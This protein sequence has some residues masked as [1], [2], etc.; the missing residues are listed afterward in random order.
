MLCVQVYTCARA[1]VSTAGVRGCFVGHSGTLTY[2]FPSRRWTQHT[3]HLLYAPLQVLLE[4]RFLSL[5]SRLIL[6]FLS[7]IVYKYQN[8]LCELITFA[9]DYF[10]LTT[11][12][13][14]EWL[15]R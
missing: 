3:L 7:E 11:D 14:A 8:I 2:P 1:R 5:L 13:L 10:R 4:A 15:R 9:S 6:D 12:T